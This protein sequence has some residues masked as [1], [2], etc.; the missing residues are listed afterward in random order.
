MLSLS[1]CISADP[2]GHNCRLESLCPHKPQGPMAT[3]RIL[4]SRT[5]EQWVLPISQ[6]T[7]LWLASLLRAHERA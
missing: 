5:P 4:D 2:C 6:C 7:R 1:N 3:L